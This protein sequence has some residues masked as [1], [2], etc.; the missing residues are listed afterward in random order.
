MRGCQLLVLIALVGGLSACAAQI[1]G[2]GQA[3]SPPQVRTTQSPE[4][5]LR[6]RATQFW[7]ARVK[8]DLATQYDLLEPAARERV[9]LTG[10]VWARNSVIFK[11]YEIQ[12]VEVAGDEGLVS[13][14]ATFRMNVPQL[15]RYGPW[16]QQVAL[17]WVIVDGLWYVRYDQQTTDAKPPVPVG[18]KRP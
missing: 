8:G 18:E 6:A 11:S 15:S 4:D 16:N 17:K 7:E 2:Q 12:T 5:A 9:T 13:A 3:A 10:Y 1:S 14:K